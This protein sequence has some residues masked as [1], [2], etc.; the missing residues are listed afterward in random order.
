M[1]RVLV[2][3]VLLLPAMTRADPGTLCSR[4]AFGPVHCIRPAHVVHDTCQAI[5]G[6][7]DRHGLDRGF[8]ARLIWQESRFDPHARSPAN[9]QGI[10]QFIP[11]TAA[12]RGLRDPWNPAEAL[13][14]D[15]LYL[16]QKGF[17]AEGY[18][19][20]AGILYS[21]DTSNLGQL[22]ANILVYNNLLTSFWSGSYTNQSLYDKGLEQY[23]ATPELGKVT[24]PTLL[25]WGRYDFVVNPEVGET[26]LQALGSADKELVYFEGSGHSP[27]DSEPALFV[28]TVITFIER[29]R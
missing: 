21:G 18:L 26:A 24:I 16:N 10:A 4:G 28:N 5:A 13:D 20:D 2:F 23:T 7:A 11:S 19:Q 14:E 25:M 17:E 29:N 1:V 22:F 8:F 12:L 27:M 9:A 3:L 6:F 15:I